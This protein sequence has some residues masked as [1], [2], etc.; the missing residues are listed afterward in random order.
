MKPGGSD[1]REGGRSDHPPRTVLQFRTESGSLY[2]VDLA[3]RRI[4]R[5][6][7]HHE[8]TARQGEDGHW[9]AYVELLPSE[10]QSGAPLLIVWG[11]QPDGNVR[12]TKTS[13]LSL[14]VP[15]ATHHLREL[16]TE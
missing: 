2:Q 11:R 8:P 6:A 1:P 3:G 9:R 16:A 10:P 7:G 13:V 12:C 14:I 15:P 5:L 4:R